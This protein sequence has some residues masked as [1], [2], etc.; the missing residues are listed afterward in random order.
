MLQGRFA[1]VVVITGNLIEVPAPFCTQLSFEQHDGR[2][3]REESTTPKVDLQLI[4]QRSH[5]PKI[6]D[7]NVSF[8]RSTI[9]LSTRP[10]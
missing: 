9:M 7:C 1:V 8:F 4:Q 10:D 3:T 6:L 2:A 5:S